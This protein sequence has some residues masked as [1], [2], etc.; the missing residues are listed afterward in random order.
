MWVTALQRPVVVIYDL[1]QDSVLDLS[2]STDRHTLLACSTDGTVA[3]IVFSE[4]EL[5]TSL[6]EDDKVG[7]L[8]I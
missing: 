4:D 6:S 7:Q 2:W 5:G 3:C 1:F 8:I